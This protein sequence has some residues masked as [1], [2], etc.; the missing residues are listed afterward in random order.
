MRRL[1]RLL[2]VALC[3]APLAAAGC[4]GSSANGPLDNALGYLPKSAPFVAVIDTNTNDGQWKSLDSNLRKL[5]FAGVLEAGL[6]NSL[7]QQGLDFNKDIK[8]LLGNEAVLGSPT[9]QA[10][11]GGTQL[12]GA[13]QVKSSGRLSSLLSRSN[14]LTRDGTAEGATLYRQTNGGGETAQKGNVLVFADTKPELLAALRQRG[15][16]GRLTADQFDSNMNGLSSKALVR[17]YVDAHAL[18]GASPSSAPA[19]RVRW[20]S[21]LRTVAVTASSQSDGIAFDFNAKTD[22]SELTDADLPLAPGSASPPVAVSPGEIGIGIRGLDQTERFAETV[23]Q[24]VSPASFGDFEN[25]KKQLGARLGIDV[26]RDLVGQFSGNSSVAFDLAGHYALRAEPRDPAAFARTL[27]KF[28]RVAPAFAQG[29]GLRGA[30]ITRAH[31]LYKLTA[32]GGKTIYY[33]MVGKVFALSDSAPML[34]QVAAPAP[35]SVPGA[36]GSV[37]ISSD[38]GRLVAG[39]LRRA[40]GGGLSGVLGGSVISQAIGRLT[41]WATTSTSGMSG[42]LQLEIR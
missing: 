29:A 11:M 12:I 9:V 24:A 39:V 40:S 8:P 19:G 20:V 4:G 15:A 23:A 32:R 22:S 25:A 42:R 31:G 13:L 37:A 41:G 1:R 30:R 14:D 34:A 18:L 21:A 33:G 5:P 7:S 2:A 26:D 6:R 10:L 28:S 27:A 3:A 36:K 17:L 38:A 16:G 35:Q